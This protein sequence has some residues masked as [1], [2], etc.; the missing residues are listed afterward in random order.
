MRIKPGAAMRDPDMEPVTKPR[1]RWGTL[2]LVIA[3]HVLVGAALIRAFAPSFPA[4]AIE[5]V[6]SLVTVTITAPPDP[7]ADPTPSAA[8][9]PGNAGEEG[10]KAT[11]RPASAPT[12]RVPVRATPLPRASSTGASNASGAR[13]EGNGTGAGGQ[14][15][16]TGSG[17]G[18]GG[19]GGGA[20]TKP[21]HI[22]G[23]IDNAR[24]Y[25]IP[26][27]GREA[28]IGKSVIVAL[29]VGTD[30]RASACRVYRASGLPETDRITC[31]LALE[32]LRFRP[33]TNAQ[34]EPV[35][36]TF[37]WQQRFFF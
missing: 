27:G 10:V 9:D 16:G 1:P 7:L 11:P 22:G 24:D 19:Q 8:P 14:G 30:G 2:A 17:A 34:G 12:A 6:G 32:R 31:T 21:V 25:P 3:G 23:K 26:E 36:G 35:V 20:A 13:D 5:A 15:T 18:G 29:T 33:A 28:R 4:Q 37:Y